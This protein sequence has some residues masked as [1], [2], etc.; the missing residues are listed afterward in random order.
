MTVAAATSSAPAGSADVTTAPFDFATVTPLLAHAL[1]VDVQRAM[2]AKDARAAADALKPIV[3]GGKLSG[4][5]VD[6]ARFLLGRLLQ[7]AKDDDAADAAYASVSNSSPLV[8]HASL[9]RA[10]IAA[11]RGK[12]DDAL[13]LLAVVPDAAPLSVDR[14]FVLGDVAAA[15]GDHKSAAEAYGAERKGPRAVEALIRYA[16]EVSALGTAGEPLALDAARGARRVRFEHPTSSLAPRAEEAEKKSRGLLAPAAAVGLG[17]PTGA[18]E[19]TSAQAFFDAGKPKD[20][21]PVAL[22]VLSVEKKGSEPWC[23]AALVIARAHERLRERGKASD[24]YGDVVAACSDE[25]THVTALYDGAK[26]ALAA[27]QPDLARAR[28]AAVE[29]DHPAH[30]LA[31]DAR[32]RGALTAIDHGDVPKGEAMLAALADDYPQGDMRA[33][34][35]F[36]L[37]LPRMKKGDWAGA[38]P[39]LEKSLAFIPR[40][41]GYF[42][43]GRVSYFFGRAKLETGA[44]EAGLLKL[45]AVI[46]EEP[47]SFSSIMAY[48]RLC[49]RSKAE[50][51]NAKKA[52]DQGIAFEPKGDL[53]DPRRPE[54]TTF[55]FARGVELACVGESDLARKELAAAGLLSDATKDPEGQWLV[56]FVFAKAG[57]SKAAHGIPRARLTDWSRHFPGGK[58]RAAW[59]IAFPRAF[60]ELVEPAAKAEGVPPTMVWAVMREE[61]AFDPDAASPSAAYGL[62]QLIVPTATRYAKPLKL[63]SDAHALLRPAVNIP[64]GTAYLKK[65]RAEFPQNPSYAVPSYNA[66]EGATHRWLTPPLADSFD[67]WVESIPY[68]E[69]R[70]YT[71]RVLASYYAYVALYEPARLE[72]ELRA[73]AGN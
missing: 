52:L 4:R 56:A 73:A 35:L 46:A 5:D 40:E 12:G 33:E 54:T 20:A 10:S 42:V 60:A 2:L 57:D 31:D 21:L 16:E 65:L 34:A 37:A 39:F 19:A 59:E 61:S 8:P 70:K 6:R 22:R 66:G 63:D 51:E 32:L 49:E 71:K 3:D 24:A 30:R 48:A 41:E 28:F 62:L 50:C 55:A 38:L 23:R 27:K 14:H 68:D 25:A 58:W 72:A 1:L 44:A 26:M 45:R 36:R 7:T 29:K 18:E 67:L 64:I 43:A 9:R 11:K 53:F 17:A 69:T 15:K 47:L 13:A